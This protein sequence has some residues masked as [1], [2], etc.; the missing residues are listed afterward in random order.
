MK[1]DLVIHFRANGSAK[2]LWTDAIDL[3]AI[4]KL[5]VSRASTIEYNNRVRLWQVK[6]KGRIVYDSHTRAGCLDW[7]ADHFNQQLLNQ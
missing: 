6:V 2:C 5:K 4:G 3:R 1:N 7:E